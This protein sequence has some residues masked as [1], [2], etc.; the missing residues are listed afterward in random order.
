MTTIEEMS[1]LSHGTLSQDEER[2]VSE[3]QHGLPLTSRPYAT[4]GARIGLSEAEVLSVVR[5]L[6]QYDIIKRFGV[7]VRHHELGYRANAMAVWDVPD[8]VIDSIGQQLSVFN[9]ITL[10]YK[11]AR[12]LPEWRFNL[13]C[14]IHGREKQAVIENIKNLIDFCSLQEY[15]HDVLFSG[16]RFKQ[17]GAIY[18]QTNA[19]DDLLIYKMGGSRS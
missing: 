9:F 17:R 10:C 4:L 14:M 8:A 12:H 3:L 2:V 18:Q 15:P 7:I 19:D 6:K 1:V 13:Y 16:R 11:R 5:R